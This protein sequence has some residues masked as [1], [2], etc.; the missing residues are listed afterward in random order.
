MAKVT[1]K[2]YA[3]VADYGYGDKTIYGRFQYKSAATRALKA[4]VDPDTGDFDYLA[5]RL[6]IVP[7][8]V[9]ITTGR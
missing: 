8:Q 5:D 7:G 9:T 3:I 2:Y 6:R 4:M 1:H